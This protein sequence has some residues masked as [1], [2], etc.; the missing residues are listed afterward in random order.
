M[1]PDD[2]LVSYALSQANFA[3]LTSEAREIAIKLLANLSRELARR[4][5]RADRTIHELEM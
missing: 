4:M 2:D 5:R 1:A 3:R